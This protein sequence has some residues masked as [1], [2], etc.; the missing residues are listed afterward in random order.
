[1]AHIGGSA[2][3]TKPVRLKVFAALP[4]LASWG[5]QAALAV[6]EVEVEPTGHD[7]TFW[8]TDSTK[9]VSAIVETLSQTD[10]AAELIAEA[11]G[12]RLF[13]LSGFFQPDDPR[14]ARAPGAL[15]GVIGAAPEQFDV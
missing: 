15:T 4:C 14:L 10:V 2:D 3:P 8:V 6:A 11:G 13:S 1:M 7:Q 9:S 5:P 12:L